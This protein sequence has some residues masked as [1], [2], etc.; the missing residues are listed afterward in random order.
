MF[1]DMTKLLVF[2]ALY[3]YSLLLLYCYGSF[4]VGCKHSLHSAYD[5]VSKQL[6]ATKLQ[7][8]S[9]SCRILKAS[10]CL[11]EFDLQEKRLLRYFSH[12][13]RKK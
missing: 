4:E 3:M 5:I 1:L 8:H 2:L 10:S 7:I 6:S 9:Y 13:L 12:E 11:P